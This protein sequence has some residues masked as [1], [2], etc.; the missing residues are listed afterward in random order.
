MQVNAHAA[1][2]PE[3]GVSGTPVRGDVQ[4]P[5]KAKPCGNTNVAST[6]DS[7][8]PVTAGANGQFTVTVTNFNAG[9]DGSRQVTATVDP[10]GAGT[11]FPG[12]VGISQ[13]G[14]L[15]PTSVGSQQV[16]ASL[17]AGTTCSGGTA[18]NLCL[19]SFTT[20]GGFGNCVVVQQ[21][22]AAS[23]A[24]TPGSAAAGNTASAS[25]ATAGTAAAAGS[26]STGTVTTGTA[27]KAKAAGGAAKTK[28]AAKA[29]AVPAA[30]PKVARNIGGT[31]AARALLGGE[32][33]FWA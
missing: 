32:T 3:L 4:R 8:T 16:V 18:G 7:S 17:P 11:S 1:I 31:R 23:G 6:L 2:V 13:N 5:S 12:T 25:G 33:W 10:T 21:G 22:G 15:A 28:A 9:K 20:A 14:D 27:K 26:S 29:K 30:T 19:V 24:A